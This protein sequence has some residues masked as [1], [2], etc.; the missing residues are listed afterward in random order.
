MARSTWRIGRPMPKAKLSVAASASGISMLDSQNNS[1]RARSVWS[2]SEASSVSIWDLTWAAIRLAWS[3]SSA[4]SGTAGRPPPGAVSLPPAGG[5]RIRA[6]MSRCSVRN[7]SSALRAESVRSSP[8]SSTNVALSA[9]SWVL[10][11]ASSLSVP[12]TW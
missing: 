5:V 10:K 4:K 6:L 3:S 1:R 9:A 12:S 7:G 11:A 8:R 2:R